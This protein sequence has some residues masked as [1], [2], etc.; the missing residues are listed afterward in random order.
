MFDP[1][2]LSLTLV[3]KVLAKTSLGPLASAIAH[4]QGYKAE[5]VVLQM[6]VSTIRVTIQ[7]FRPAMSL[8]CWDDMAIRAP[9]QQAPR[10]S[11]LPNLGVPRGI[12]TLGGS[13][14]TCVHL[15][16]KTFCLQTTLGKT[17]PVTYLATRAFSC[18]SR[19]SG[20]MPS[21]L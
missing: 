8:I 12:G 14:T 17:Q 4:D 20:P 9:G 2:R 21:Q 1:L 15:S 13:L 6:Q 10:G 18:A 3:M 5:L 11:W 16:H 19:V 7:K